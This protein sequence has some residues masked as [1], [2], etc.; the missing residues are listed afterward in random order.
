VPP[1]PVAGAA[2]GTGLGVDVG[3][4]V[5]RGLVVGRGRVGGLGL[6]VGLAVVV[7]RGGVV[8]LADV[9]GRTLALDVGD[10]EPLAPGEIAGGVA[11]G[12]DPEQ[13]EMDT[14]ASIAKAAQPTVNLALRGVPMMVVRILM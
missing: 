4:A 7:G 11:E 12:V 1:P 2:V 9:L 10:G 5:G 3:L 14:D 13:A 6:V 8:G